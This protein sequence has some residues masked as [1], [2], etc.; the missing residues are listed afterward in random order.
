MIRGTPIGAL[1]L[2]AFLANPDLPHR[3]KVGAALNVPEAATFYG[4][5]EKGYLDYPA[6]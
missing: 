5:D 6:L 2:L 3:L 4:G 1:T